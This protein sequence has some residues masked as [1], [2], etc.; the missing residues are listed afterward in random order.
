MAN[1]AVDDLKAQWLK[2]GESNDHGVPFAL[3]IREQSVK[4]NG[5]TWKAIRDIDS[6]ACSTSLHLLETIFFEEQ[7]GNWSST[8]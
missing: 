7:A 3:M 1:A 6:A 2:S 4:N 5:K 8:K